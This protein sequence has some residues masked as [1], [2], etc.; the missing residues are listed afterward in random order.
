VRAEWLRAEALVAST[1]VIGD[2]GYTPPM[3]PRLIE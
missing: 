3:G 1:A 2:R